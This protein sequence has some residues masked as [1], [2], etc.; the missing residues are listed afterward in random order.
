MQLTLHGSAPAVGLS[1]ALHALVIAGTRM[2]AHHAT[3][4][5][6]SSVEIAIETELVDAP[7]PPSAPEPPPP[8]E[9]PEPAP[10]KVATAHPGPVAVRAVAATEPAKAIEPAPPADAPNALASDA[11]LPHFAIATSVKVGEEGSLAK[12]SGAAASQGAP[13]SD[14]PYAEDAVDTPAR[15]ARK[16]SPRYPLEAQS[17][18]A[19]ATVKLEI[20][21][22]ATGSVL[23]VRALNHPGHGFEEE[24]LAAARRTLFTAATKRGRA[25]PVRMAWTV[26]FRLQ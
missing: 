7:A 24:A 4:V 1:L 26:E 17:S 23:S 18:G 9:P 5:R 3:P 21:L 19:E 15:A 12:T 2:H 8:N 16:V 10:V 14:P 11:A 25:V 22:S 6:P 20:V 13:E